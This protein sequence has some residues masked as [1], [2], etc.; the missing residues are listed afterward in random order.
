MRS[1]VISLA[2]VLLWYSGQV[3]AQ[4]ASELLIAMPACAVS[5]T[6]K[7]FAWTNMNRY[8]VSLKICTLHP[9]HFSISRVFVPVMSFGEWLC[10]V[11]EQIVQQQMLWVSIGRRHFFGS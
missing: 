10:Y 8:N 3:Q 7:T 2:A 5:T 9:V 11:V 1:V 4:S 6:G